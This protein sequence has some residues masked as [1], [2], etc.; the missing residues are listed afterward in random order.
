MSSGKVLTI[1]KQLQKEGKFTTIPL[2]PKSKTSSPRFR[3]RFEPTN[4]ISSSPI[5]KQKVESSDSESDIKMSPKKRPIIEESDD[6]K[7]TKY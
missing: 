4:E 3:F 1:K 5:K 6:E 2:S 7:T